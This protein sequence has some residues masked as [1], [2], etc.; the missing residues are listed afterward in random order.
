MEPQRSI[1]RLADGRDL[2][3]LVGGADSTEAFLM[4][5][6][7][8]SGVLARGSDVDAVTERGLRYVTYGRPGYADSTRVPGRSV[9]DIAP[10]VRELAGLL[11][12]SR[13][14]VLGWSGG[15]PHALACAAL[16]PDLVAGAATV[17]GVA[18]FDAEGLVWLDGMAPEN[19]E[20]FGAAVAGPRELEEKLDA[21]ASDLAGATAASIAD[22]FGELVSEVDRAA[23]TGDFADFLAA[24]CR[25]SI[26]TGIW[27]WF[28]DDL[29]FIR[30]W[31]FDLSAIRVPVTIWQGTEDRMVPFA[32]GRWL[33]AHVT[34]A[35]A[36]LM[37]GEGH[38]SLGVSS[39]GRIL[40]EL[41]MAPA[42]SDDGDAPRG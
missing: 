25:D 2:D 32:H 30:D 27:G 7:T 28:D 12:L 18:P 19:H 4:I 11:G 29:A 14:H 1:V 16:L 37:E 42:R 20:E 41:I 10:D 36:R 22:A 17:G 3:V 5:N 38:L 40:D 33:S 21:F 34:N 15:G 24:S 39:F 9:A 26:R 6:G 8:P 13:L 23:L 35:R 31:G